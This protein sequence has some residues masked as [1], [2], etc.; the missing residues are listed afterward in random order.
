MRTLRAVE[1]VFLFALAGFGVRGIRVRIGDFGRTAVFAGIEGVP[2]CDEGGEGGN[3]EDVA[4]G[5]GCVLA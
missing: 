5:G 1:E 2:G 3:A 4:V